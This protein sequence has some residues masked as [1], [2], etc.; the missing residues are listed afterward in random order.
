MHELTTISKAIE[1]LLTNHVKIITMVN[2]L[3]NIVRGNKNSGAFPGGT[4]KTLPNIVTKFW[5]YAGSRLV[6]NHEVCRN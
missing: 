2:Y 5:I 3:I 4:M 1:A 6:E